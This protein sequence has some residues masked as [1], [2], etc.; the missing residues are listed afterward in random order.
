MSR[1]D[2]PATPPDHRAGADADDPGTNADDHGPDGHG[3]DGRSPDGRGAATAP[4]VT[5]SGAH[6]WRRGAHRITTDRAEI[7]VDV[8]HGFLSHT[9]WAAG[10][11]RERIERCIAGSIPFG[12]FE[13]LR[14]VGFAR[15]ISDRATFAYVHDVFVLPDARGR[16]LGVWLMAT[17]L[18]HPDLA[19]LRRWSLSTRDAHL[20]YARFGFRP[21]LMPHRQME[22]RPDGAAGWPP[23]PPRTDQPRRTPRTPGSSS[24]PQS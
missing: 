1:A 16:G 2:G 24:M 12:L 21:V 3:A 18:A 7:D 9:Y 8:V 22:F 20:L 17:V 5:A 19:D 11:S 10:I 15:V 6:E 23:L 4:A 13:G 14:Q